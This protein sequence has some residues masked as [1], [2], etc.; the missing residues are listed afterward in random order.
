ME[1]SV[2]RAG[3]TFIPVTQTSEVECLVWTHRAP[4]TEQA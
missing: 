4:G 2:Q 3:S 1:T